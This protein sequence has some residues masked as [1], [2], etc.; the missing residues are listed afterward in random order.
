MH[1]PESSRSTQ[2]D[3]DR[4]LLRSQWPA[5]DKLTRVDVAERDRIAQD[6]LS[7]EHEATQD[8]KRNSIPP[9]KRVDAQSRIIWENL[10]PIIGF[11][12]LIPLA[13]LPYVFSW[14]GVLAVPALNYIFGSLGILYAK[15][16]SPYPLLKISFPF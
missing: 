13:C 16:A 5:D 11:H 10:I 1:S 15:F 6:I 7:D 8:R 2:K 3:I 14:W 4:R 12:L 9:P